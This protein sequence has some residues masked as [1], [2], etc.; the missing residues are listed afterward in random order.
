MNNKEKLIIS[1]L[2]MLC[3]SNIVFSLRIVALKRAAI[4]NEEYMDSLEEELYILYAK[5]D[6][7]NK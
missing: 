5:R 3:V 4:V 6:T 1:I 7:S 2:L